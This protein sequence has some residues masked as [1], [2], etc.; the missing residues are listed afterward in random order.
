MSSLEKYYKEKIEPKLNDKKLENTV[1]TELAKMV[2]GA[3]TSNMAS[4]ESFCFKFSVP[5]IAVNNLYKILNINPT[6]LGIVYKSDWG[7]TLTAMH[8]DPYYQILLLLLYH[9]IITNKELFAK[10]ALMVIL[11]KIWNGRRSHFFTKYCDKRIMKYVVNN[12]MTK[13]HSFNK[14]ENPVSLLK[15][16]FVPTIYSKYSSE[17]KNDI[18]KLKRLFEQCFAR[19]RQLFVFNTRTNLKTGSPEAQGGLLPLYMKA[20]KEGLYL[21]TISNNKAEDENAPGFEEY[22]TTHNRDQIVDK[23][24]DY[25]VMNK[26]NYPP[27]LINSI[28]SKT[29]VSIKIIEKILEEMHSH[30]NLEVIQNIIILILSRCNVS[31]VSD[32]CSSSFSS[33][34]QK[35][36][37]SSKNNEDVNKIQRLLDHLLSQIFK[38]KLNIDFNNYSSVHKIKIRNVIIFALEYDLFR[39]NCRGA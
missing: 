27:N 25:I 18:H 5:L 26:V 24:V 1:Y 38:E 35:N 14:Y 13:R 22:A 28:N 37:I 17:I 8:K 20:Y 31:N 11:I 10:N 23:T 9:G 32:I 16:Y 12:M 3:Y 21:T 4:D 33:K 29:N 2:S 39:V 7:Q 30:S 15:D 19:V 34:I 6:E 36:I